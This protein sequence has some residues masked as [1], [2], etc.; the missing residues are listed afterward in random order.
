[1]GGFGIALSA[2]PGKLRMSN[3]SY[4][5]IDIATVYIGSAIDHIMELIW[6]KDTRIFGIKAEQ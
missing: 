1:M 5:A 4:D 6:L 2:R 3:S